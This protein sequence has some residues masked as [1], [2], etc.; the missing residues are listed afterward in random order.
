M[1]F[2]KKSAAGAVLALALGGGMVLAATPASAA[3]P[4][5]D[6]DPN[7]NGSISFFN[8]AGKQV[9]SGSNLSH[10]F[11]FALASSA[12]DP[13]GFHKAN[14]QFAY[15]DHNQP[16][17]SLWFVNGGS[18]ATTYPNASAPA[19]L[20]TA[21]N[22]LVTVGPLEMN[23]TAAKG[24]AVLD[25]TAGYANIVTIRETQSS[26]TNYWASDIQYNTANNTW[27]QVF[28]VAA[29]TTSTTVSAAPSPGTTGSPVT[30][31]ATVQTGDLLPGVGTVQFKDGATN[32]GSPVTV[33]G[34]GVATLTTSALTQGAHTIN[35]D[36]TP[37]DSSANGQAASSGTTSETVN[38]PAPADNTTTA[39]TGSS[40][41]TVGAGQ[42]VTATV[43]DTTT[44]ATKPT[45]VVQFTVDGT[46]VGSPVALVNGVA[47]LQYVPADTAPHTIKGAYTPS[48][49]ALFNASSDAV[50]L[51]VTATAPAFAPDPQNFTVTVPAG[52]LVIS[53][54]Y[55]ASHPFNLGT[56][57]LNGTGTQYATVPVPF[58]TS[59]TAG[60]DPGNLD[61][62]SSASLS[63]GVTITD[64]RAASHGWTASAQVTSTGGFSDG[65]G[66]NID[67][68][69]LS[70][71]G[72]TAKYIAGN[73][74][75]A[76]DVT[77]NDITAFQT[78]A[79][80]FATTAKG[81]GTVNV[82]GDMSLVAPTSTIAGVY[83]G[84]VTF[85]I[86]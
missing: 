44:P 19:P 80:S 48:N 25:T 34:S 59:A 49:P 6:P 47:T 72:V 64:T 10:L 18:P 56:L 14:V 55:T 4:T 3:A 63:N 57:Q 20:N 84:T 86:V 27:R 70:F 15:P 17:P 78:T 69:G 38:A 11:D 74:L 79:K 1:K 81:P 68:N 13:G 73:H 39:V 77:T 35:A 85:T 52:T 21:T 75:V 29:N 32:L 54:P 2:S 67:G 45:G 8:T 58:G 41:G 50:G 66:H 82:F 5:W 60:T 9:T 62:N 37:A 24:G 22:P 36:F 83:T 31:T 43:S 30:L 28:P 65:G 42:P 26:G 51:T 53:T 12:E 46:N 7:A 76:G 71:S 16:D 23:L 61:A 40:T 33:N